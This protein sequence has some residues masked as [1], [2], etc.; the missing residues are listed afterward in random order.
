MGGQILI[1]P[2][3]MQAAGRGLVLGEE[4]EVHAKGI[5]EALHEHPLIWTAADRTP[6]FSGCQN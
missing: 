3:L 6:P 4:V 5:R 1:S 2:A